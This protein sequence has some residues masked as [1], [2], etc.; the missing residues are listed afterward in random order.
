MKSRKTPC[1]RENQQGVFWRKTD[2]QK[3]CGPGFRQVRIVLLLGI[4]PAIDK[5]IQQERAEYP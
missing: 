3:D 5:I 2:K 1:Q 4:T